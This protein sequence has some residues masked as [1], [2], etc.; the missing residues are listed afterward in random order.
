MADE[1]KDLDI[2]FGTEEEVSSEP[3]AD[4]ESA[5]E[6]PAGKSGKT[7][8]APAAKKELTEEQ[9]EALIAKKMEAGKAKEEPKTEEEQAEADY[10]E[11]LLA[12]KEFDLDKE[13]PRI[14][15][16]LHKSRQETKRALEELKRITGEHSQFAEKFGENERMS[17][18]KAEAG[19]LS[20]EELKAE[21]AKRTNELLGYDEGYEPENDDDGRA[22]V[23]AANRMYKKV[24]EEKKAAPKSTA[25]TRPVKKTEGASGDGK[26]AAMK[27]L[28]AEGIDFSTL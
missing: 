8:D 15:A 25:N 16:E 26:S 24:L 10:I 14:L 12:S 13:F 18:L 1:I 5:T 23:K 21:A 27:R 7:A 2:D 17:K 28:E 3:E 4:A 20:V 9:V 19:D 11:G 22:W 6:V